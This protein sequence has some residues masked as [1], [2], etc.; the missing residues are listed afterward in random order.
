VTCEYVPSAQVEA[1]EKT[2]PNN[3]LIVFVGRKLDWLFVLH[4][5]VFIR[6]GEGGGRL[7][8]ASSKHG[9]VMSFDLGEYVREQ[10]NRYL[11]F[12]AYRIHDP[13]G[14]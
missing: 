6:D 13:N 11:G 4:C 5:G 14:N 2:L 12:A 9:A 8:E 1:A 7:I 3:S 10:G